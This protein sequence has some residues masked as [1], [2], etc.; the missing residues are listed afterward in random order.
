M[1]L[2]YSK[3]QFH[4]RHISTAG[5]GDENAVPYIHNLINADTYMIAAYIVRLISAFPM[6]EYDVREYLTKEGFGNTAIVSLIINANREGAC[7]RPLWL[8]D[9]GG[10]L[11]PL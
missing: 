7:D 10:I 8:R 5:F 3:V 9:E 2:D 6:T 11:Q 4:A 1:N